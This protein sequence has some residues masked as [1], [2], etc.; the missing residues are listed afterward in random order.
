VL[1]ILESSEP[2][3]YFSGSTF[4]NSGATY[5]SSTA[6]ETVDAY[7]FSYWKLNGVRQADAAG[8]AL[9]PVTFVPTVNT[10]LVAVYTLATADTDND[11][12]PDSVE[13]EF[14]GDLSKTAGAD[15]DAD[16]LG[17]AL[18]KLLGYHPSLPDSVSEG[19]LSARFS[20]VTILSFSNDYYAV[21]TVSDPPGF[22]DPSTQYVTGTTTVTLPAAPDSVNGCRFAGWYLGT[23]RADSPTTIQPATLSVSEATVFTA[24]YILESAD[25]DGDGIL[26]WYEWFAFSGLSQAADSDSDSDEL[27]LASEQTLGFA[28]YLTDTVSEG[29]LAMRFSTLSDLNLAG[30]HSLRITSDPLG[31]QVESMQWGEPGGTL[32]TPDLFASIVDGY[33]FVGWYV[34]GALVKD[35]AN[36]AA[37][38]ASILMNADRV[39]VAK[40]VL[41]TEDADEDGISD[42]QEMLYNGALDASRTTDA[43]GDGL[44]LSSEFLL[45]YHPGLVDVVSEGGLSMRFSPVTNTVFEWMP[46]ITRQ[47]LAQ[48]LKEGESASLSVEVSSPLGSSYQWRKDGISLAGATGATLTIPSANTTDAGSYSVVVSGPTGSVTSRSAK[49]TVSVNAGVSDSKLPA[50]ISGPISHRVLIP[51]DPLGYSASNLPAGVVFN[52]STGFVSGSPTQ[53]GTYAVRITGKSQGA[54]PLNFDINVARLDPRFV[55][56][57]Q[58]WIERNDT[59][60][61]N[62][63]S[64]IQITTTTRGAYSGRLVTGATAITFQGSLIAAPASSTSAQQTARILCVLPKTSVTLDVSL[65]SVGNLMSGTLSDGSV[66]TVAVDGWRNVWPTTPGNATAFG[67]LHTFCVRQPDDADESL[68]QGSGFGSLLVSARSGSS[69]ITT[70]LSDGAKMSS[71]TFV[72]PNGE[73][74]LYGSLYTNLGSVVGRLDIDS[75]NNVSGS[76]TWMRPDLSAKPALTYRVGFAPI[77]V[78]VSGGLYVP[79]N[80]GELILGL[81]PGEENAQLIFS[82]G[83]LSDDINQAVTVTSLGS[84]SALN[85]ITVPVNINQVRVTSLSISTGA[86]S[87]SFTLPGATAVDAARR[88]SFYGQ[89][90]QTPGGAVSGYGYFLLPKPPAVG[91]T[92]TTAPRLS[93]NVLLRAP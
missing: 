12:L 15:P 56:T 88:A 52:P 75:D 53:A 70:S 40:Y 38:S 91:Q 93:G 26:D 67:G 19:G 51:T 87:G 36:A 85:R 29:G 11:G 34:D 57:F 2:V 28:P 63:G 68:P 37:G 54:V 9:N 81:S 43:D 24:K 33:R 31:L 41:G 62:L 66:N 74:F 25:T 64:I 23:A 84:R 83:G 77:E 76:P 4:Q 27:G 90:V 65:D 17:N 10:T 50:V 5:T 78:N 49:L 18:E 6:P 46:V 60:N 89:I 47:P 21:Q 22:V 3:G 8:R 13:M 92:M 35:A 82:N 39:V 14:F 69:I 44:A 30:Y 79:P 73:V 71:A 80:K 7:R 16:G 20:P 32:Q 86:F 72:G 48:E 42:W 55:G 58:G 1:A 61:K 45:A 59:L